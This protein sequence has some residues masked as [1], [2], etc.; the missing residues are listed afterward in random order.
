MY[1]IYIYISISALVLFQLSLTIHLPL[2]S[3]IIC[4]NLL[5]H[6]PGSWPRGGRSI[7]WAS[8]P[9]ENY[10]FIPALHL[11]P[12]PSVVLEASKESVEFFL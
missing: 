7:A 11:T 3:E 10:A 6:F 4:T 9:S 2:I 8:T 5:Y 12:A 1:I